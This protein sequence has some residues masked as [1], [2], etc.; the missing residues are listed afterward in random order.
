MIRSESAIFEIGISIPGSRGGLRRWIPEMRVQLKGSLEMKK[1]L[2]GLLIL[3]AFVMV[4]FCLWKETKPGVAPGTI[5]FDMKYRGLSGA[6][7]ELRYN[8]Y[9][10]F[11]ASK[12]KSPFIAEVRK[13][14]GEFSTVY[15]SHFKGAEW[16]AVEVKDSKAVAF[17]FDL[18]ADGQVSENE[19]ILPLEGVE[20][21]AGNRDG[22]HLLSWR[23]GC[24]ASNRC[25]LRGRRCPRH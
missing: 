11:G 12:E 6:K 13:L 22:P 21:D 9:W 23:D 3:V 1:S 17:Y 4:V 10:G 5:V 25:G 2:I 15:N 19:K 8:S 18:N 20:P 7:D 16:S 14:D 24:G